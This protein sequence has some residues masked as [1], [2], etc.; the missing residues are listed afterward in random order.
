MRILLFGEY[1]GFYNCLRDGLIDLGHEV[2]IASDGDGYK[3]YPADFR[4]DK[5]PILFMGKNLLL[6]KFMRNLKKISNFDVVLVISFRPLGFNYFYNRFI[7]NYLFNN[8]EKVFISGAG[9]DCNNFDYW[10]TCGD[11][12]LYNW[13]SSNIIESKEK[14][15]K[16]YFLYNNKKF[17]EFEDSILNRS[18]GYIPITYEYSKFLEGHKKNKKAIPLPIN[19]SKFE[20]QKNIYDDKVRF[21]HGKSRR[22]KGGALIE[23]AF[24]DL[25]T[26]EYADKF[27]FKCVGGLPFDEYTLLLNNSNVI[28]DNINSHSYGMNQLISMAKG[29]VVLGGGDTIGNDFLYSAP[30]PGVSV[31]ANVDDIKEKIE[32][33]INNRSYIEEWGEQSRHFVEYYHDYH[34][35]AQQYI[36]TFNEN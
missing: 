2:F 27:D 32:Y 25:R 22:C 8:N 10:M 23:D 35:V 24:N 16:K 11:E 4:Y 36:D 31:K 7:F 6:L 15:E 34:K 3:N 9:L 21:F 33:I 29:R 19:L 5:D 20:Y 13:A 18:S 14:K 30:S 26:S 12:K 28:V 17:K 1:S